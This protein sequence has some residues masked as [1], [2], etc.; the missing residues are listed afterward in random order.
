[1]YTILNFTVLIVKQS[2]KVMNIIIS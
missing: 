2:Y 1:M